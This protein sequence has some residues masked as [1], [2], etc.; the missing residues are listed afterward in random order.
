VGESCVIH[1]GISL[2]CQLL[3]NEAQRPDVISSQSLQWLAGVETVILRGDELGTIAVVNTSS[4]R[5]VRYQ[6][7]PCVAPGFW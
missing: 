5:L 1:L 4:A 6:P 2:A 7:D 3:I